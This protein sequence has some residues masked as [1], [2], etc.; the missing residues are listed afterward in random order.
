LL[1]TDMMGRVV[2]TIHTGS[3]EP[4]ETRYFIHADRY[5]AGTYFIVLQPENGTAITEKLMIR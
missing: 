5:A 2:E 4:G 3:F 1:L